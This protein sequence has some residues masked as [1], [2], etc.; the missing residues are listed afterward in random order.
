MK[1]IGTI[2]SIVVA[3]AIAVGIASAGSYEAVDMYNEPISSEFSSEIDGFLLQPISGGDP[4]ACGSGKPPRCYRERCG[5]SEDLNSWV[6]PAKDQCS[7]KEYC[8]MLTDTQGRTVCATQIACA[9][10]AGGGGTIA[11][12]DA[13]DAGT[14]T[15][16]Q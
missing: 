3:L 9:D 14:N 11:I 2:G 8:T 6:C 7:G 12:T 5:L 10:S 16:V 15:K 13:S 4:G 1:T